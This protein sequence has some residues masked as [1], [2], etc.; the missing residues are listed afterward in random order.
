MKATP[1]W[2]FLKIPNADGTFSILLSDRLPEDEI[3]ALA[4]VGRFR[5][6][7]PSPPLEPPANVDDREIP[8]MVG[9]ALAVRL[10]DQW[11][12]AGEVPTTSAN[13]RPEPPSYRGRW[14]DRAGS[15]RTLWLFGG[16]QWRERCCGNIAVQRERC[17]LPRLGERQ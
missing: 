7:G 8:A 9:H 2:Q 17:Y 15:P 10:R 13:Q 12:L 11:R 6:I 16:E 14:T 1:S 4:H 5:V 3:H